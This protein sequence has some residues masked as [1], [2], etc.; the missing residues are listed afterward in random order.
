MGHPIP[1]FVLHRKGFTLPRS[2]ARR[3]VGSYPTFSP[4][5]RRETGR[6]FSVALAVIQSSLLNAFACAK[7]PAR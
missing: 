7:R 5:P 1:Y 3:A 6:L 2:V 4:L